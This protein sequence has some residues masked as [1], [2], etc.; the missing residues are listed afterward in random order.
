[1]RAVWFGSADNATADAA[2]TFFTPVTA[3]FQATWG[4][5]R[6]QKAQVIGEAITLTKLYVY[7]GTAPGGSASWTYAIDDDNAATAASVTITAGATSGSW[8]GSAAVAANSFIS[9]RATPS[10]TPATT[11][12]CWWWVEYETAGNYFLM[13]GGSNTAGSTTVTH[14]KTP[15][16]VGAGTEMTTAT[17]AEVVIPAAGTITRCT[18]GLDIDAGTAPDAYAVSVRLNDTSDNLTATC[19]ADNLT[20]TATGSLAVVA[21]DRITCKSVPT[22]TPSATSRVTTSLTIEPTVLGETWIGW[23]GSHAIGTGTSAVYD[24]TMGRGNNGWSATESTKYSKLPSYYLRNLYI[25]C[26]TAPGGV[27]VRTF[28]IMDNTAATALA[29]TVTGAGTTGNNTADRVQ[30]A[31]GGAPMSLRQVASATPV[32]SSARGGFVIEVPQGAAGHVVPR[33]DYRTS[34]LLNDL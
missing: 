11:A 18:V 13:L 15:C 30:L 33:R 3:A 23:G 17:D 8:E 27:V 32:T 20:A 22:S 26:N 24:Q 16:G 6:I 9:I 4:T 7:C 14:F 31:G 5:T 1:M 21:G 28:T 2:S 10:G 19:T 12:D 25:K 29:C 34:A